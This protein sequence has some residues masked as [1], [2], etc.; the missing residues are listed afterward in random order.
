VAIASNKEQKLTGNNFIIVMLL[1]SLL[2]VGVSGLVVKT[3]FTAIKRDLKVA[4]AKSKADKQLTQDLDNAPRLVD[5]FNSLGSKKALLQ[6]ALPNTVD[7]PSLIVELENMTGAAGIKLKS[8]DPSNVNAAD[9]GAGS[10]PAPTSG[11][12][13][14]SPQAYD[15]SITI[16]TT[17]DNLQKFL[18][19][20]ETS[21]RPTRV[22]GLQVSG[23]GS[24]LSGQMD[25]ETYYQDKAQL[26]LGK[27]TIK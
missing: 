5:A 23:N 12:T 2:V 11:S 22:V 26:P 8:V 14:P 21:A 19:N 24:S 7:F 15:F 3:L 25:L 13:A 20:L 1:I 4:Q 18:Q 16:D 17:Y 10:T 9:S 27:E 6:D